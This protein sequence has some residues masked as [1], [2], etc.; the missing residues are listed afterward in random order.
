MMFQQQQVGG[1][2]Q[3]MYNQV[4][5]VLWLKR[6]GETAD[7]SGCCLSPF[8]PGMYPP[9]QMQQMYRNAGMGMR[10]SN[11]VMARPYGF[12]GTA[13]RGQFPPDAMVPER[14]D[15]S[16]LPQAPPQPPPQQQPQPGQPPPQPQQPG[17][18]VQAQP[19]PPMG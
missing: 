6:G 10:G 1:S 7:L 2:Q 19:P 3:M 18:P 4:S 13:M 11:P 16:P 15:G 5:G 17:Q 12:P 8:Q 9:G 14:M